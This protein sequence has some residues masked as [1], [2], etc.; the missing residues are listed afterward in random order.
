MSC[1]RC[2][3]FSFRGLLDDY[4]SFR[5]HF[6]LPIR[7]HGH[8]E[9]LAALKRRVKPF[10]MRRTKEIVA[11]ELPPRIEQTDIC[12]LTEPQA[13]LYADVLASVREDVYEAV[14]TKA[15]QAFAD[16]HFVRAH[17]VASGVQ[18]PRA[19]G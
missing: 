7:N 9:T 10:M 14:R 18:S 11:P 12:P 2:L 13:A 5:S 6:E 17:K 3:I 19:R 15:I 16:C 1:G 8:A 4:P